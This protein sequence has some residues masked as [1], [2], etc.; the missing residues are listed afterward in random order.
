MMGPDDSWKSSKSNPKGMLT[1]LSNGMM[2]MLN[3]NVEKA[4]NSSSAKYHQV[5]QVQ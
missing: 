4:D 1:K 2:P 5:Q 3:S